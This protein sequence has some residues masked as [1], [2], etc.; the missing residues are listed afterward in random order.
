MKNKIILGI[1]HGD[2]NG[3]SYEVILK[4]LLDTRIY[5]V[6]TPILYGSAK[7]AAYHRKALNLPAQNINL[8]KSADEATQRKAYLINCINDEIRVEL[9]KSTP[10]AGESSYSALQKAVTDLKEG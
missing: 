1:S 8:I 10:M 6:C 7:V 5:E 2:V 3:I 9:G 4:T